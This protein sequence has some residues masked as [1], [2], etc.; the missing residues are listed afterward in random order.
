LLRYWRL[1][2]KILFKIEEIK[3]LRRDVYM[4]RRTSNSED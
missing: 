2:R 1:K 4:I 3:E